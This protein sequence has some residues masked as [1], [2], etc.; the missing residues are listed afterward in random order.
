MPHGHVISDLH[1]FARRCVFEKYRASVE[2][3]AEASDVFVLNGDVVDFSWSVLPTRDETLRATLDWV[4]TFV[5]RH[6]GC[7]FHYVIGNHDHVTVFMEALR[8]LAGETPNLVYHEHAVRFGD[9]LF[10]HGD[11]VTAHA[12]Q[13]HFIE[14]RRQHIEGHCR[15]GPMAHHMYEVVTR[16]RAVRAV[17]VVHSKKRV[18]A[19][20]L[21][22]MRREMPQHLAAARHIYFGHTHVAFTGYEMDGRLFHNTGCAIR[23]MPFKMLEFDTE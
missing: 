22:Y 21:R 3:A 9:R 14:Q 1:L 18:C 4:R 23:G 6:P 20:L 17:E 19:R 15:R 16:L 2:D 7:D 5:G 10:L 11:A 13:D 12:S 8:G